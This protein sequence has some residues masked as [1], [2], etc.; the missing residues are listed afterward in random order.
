MSENMKG[1]QADITIGFTAGASNASTVAIT[2]KDAAGNAVSEPYLLDVWLSDAATGLGLTATAS[3]SAAAIVSGYGSI[4]TINTAKK[5]WDVQTNASGEARI[6]IT[7]TAKTR[8]YVGVRDP[9]SGRSLVS[10]K[11][12]TADYT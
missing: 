5:C 3:S 6:T 2:V 12:A 9:R 7:D 8:F 1:E 4:F 11:M 10:A